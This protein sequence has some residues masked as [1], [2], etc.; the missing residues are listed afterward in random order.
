MRSKMGETKGMENG[1]RHV[2]FEGHDQR[3]MFIFYNFLFSLFAFQLERKKERVRKKGKNGR[4]NENAK[5][6]QIEAGRTR[7]EAKQDEFKR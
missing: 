4:A 3:F 1:R 2:K 7:A 6:K 5:L